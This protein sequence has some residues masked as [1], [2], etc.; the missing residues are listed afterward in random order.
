V[1]WYSQ[2]LTSSSPSQ[3]ASKAGIPSRTVTGITDAET[4][5]DSI[6]ALQ[7][8]EV[9]AIFTVDVFN[10]GIDIPQVDTVLLLR[11]TESAT[12][13]LQQLGRGLRLAEGK[14]GLTVLDFIGQQRREF[15]FDARFQALTGIPSQKLIAAIK[16]D[17]PYLP[18]GCYVHLDRVA[19]EIVLGN[20]E[21][22][23]HTRRDTLV[24]ELRECGDVSLETYLTSADRSLLDV[25][26]GTRP[27]WMQLRRD[28]GL[29][30]PSLIDDDP[31]LVKSIGRMFHIDDEERLIKYVEWLRADVPPRDDALSPRD[32]R[33]LNMLHFD[34]WG[35]RP[36]P[37]S[38]PASLSQL[39]IHEG[40][41]LELAEV[42][43]VLSAQAEGLVEE[44]V[45]VTEP[46]AV[47]AHYTRDEAL[48]ALGAA[49]PEHPPTM[50]EGVA[51][52]EE[53]KADIFFVTL[54]KSVKQFSATTM[55]R[56]YAISP[57]E[58]H[59]ESQSTT[60]IGSKTGQ[61]YINH[62]K[63][64]TRVLL[65]ARET[66]ESRDFLYLGPAHYVRH[67]GDRPIS[68]TWRLDWELPPAFFLE[69][70]AVS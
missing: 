45:S 6:H 53:A 70:R 64:G 36:A 2:N 15:R 4:R 47:H 39:W 27:G 49:S 41:R 11:P 22:A 50:R 14:S 52:I 28:A 1:K 69:A 37:L 32:L 63:S 54:R 66:S 3:T 65:F 40:V 10:E 7:N 5:S 20:L 33:L 8:R 17:F 23:H 51:W 24:R 13:F 43:D 38:L 44:G 68:I 60:S 34:F 35:R 48:A 16:D 57:S 62:T 56:D 58:F 25:Y 30:T 29:P 61:H 18:A 19:A 12:V 55:Y 67:S 31:V 59:W 26:R 9:N 21:A 46:L 42:L